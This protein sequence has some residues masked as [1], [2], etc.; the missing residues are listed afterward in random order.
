MLKAELSSGGVLVAR[1]M[2]DIY[3][4]FDE[5]TNKIGVGVRRA[6]KFGSTQLHVMRLGCLEYDSL[7][8]AQAEVDAPDVLSFAPR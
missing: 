7:A 1:D 4:C 6:W 2:I 3:L 5:S 8:N